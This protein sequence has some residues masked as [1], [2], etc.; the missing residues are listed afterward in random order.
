MWTLGLLRRGE[1]L[2]STAMP[3]IRGQ[4]ADLARAVLHALTA[5]EPPSIPI[6]EQCTPTATMAPPAPLDPAVGA[7]QPR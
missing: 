5:T 3:E 6:G 2:E 7:A 4:A 1:L